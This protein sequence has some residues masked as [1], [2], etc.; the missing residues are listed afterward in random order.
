[1]QIAVYIEIFRKHF[2][3]NEDIFTLFK[4]YLNHTLQ[5]Y[6]WVNTIKYKISI[7]SDQQ[8]TGKSCSDIPEN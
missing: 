6:P 4:S 5:V 2:F 3:K 7:S 1:M 8:Y